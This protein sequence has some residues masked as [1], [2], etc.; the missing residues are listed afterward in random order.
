M[1][2]SVLGDF[3]I[4]RLSI[5]PQILSLQNSIAPLPTL[6]TCHLLLLLL[7]SL[8]LSLALCPSLPLLGLEPGDTLCEFTGGK[9]EP[10]REQRGRWPGACTQIAFSARPL[11]PRKAGWLESGFPKP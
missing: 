6:L 3:F 8:A 7:A 11:L 10:D 5:S 1:H 9:R 4:A 2:P